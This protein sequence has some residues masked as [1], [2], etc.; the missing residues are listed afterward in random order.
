MSH[1]P[2]LQKEVLEFL[3]PKQNENF[4]DATIGGGGHAFEILKRIAPNGKVLG[5]DA[6]KETIE[7][8]EK[9]LEGQ[10]KNRLILFCD[11]FSN[12]QD[13]VRKHKFDSV[14]GILADLGFSSIELETS[15]RGFSFL[16]DEPLDMR[17]GETELTAEKIINDWKEEE[18]VDIFHEYGEERFGRKIAEIIVAA[19]RIKKISTTFDLVNII[20]KAT[21]AFYHHRRL[22]PATKVFQALRIAVNDELNNLSKFL[23]QAVDVL[24]KGGRLI[25]ISFHSLEDRIVKK[26]FKE[27]EQVNLIK[28][29]TKK[30]IRPLFEEVASN[31]RSR[32]AKLRAAIKN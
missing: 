13:I 10:I 12:L 22:N 6:N 5:I 9:K 32:S 16:K 3:S 11:N 18:L 14:R 15:G 26:I 23:S 29:L 19:R 28:I 1:T 4:I 7:S 17:Y 2:V 25:I 20:K 21:P 27:K 31:P 30:N 24:D 8:L